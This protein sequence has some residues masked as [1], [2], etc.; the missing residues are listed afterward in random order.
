MK[1]V[2]FQLVDD[3]KYIALIVDDKRVDSG[4]LNQKSYMIFKHF[5]AEAIKYAEVLTEG[6]EREELT[7]QFMDMM[8]E[9]VMDSY[10]L[11]FVPVR[12][13]PL[14]EG[15]NEYSAIRMG[16]KY[17]KQMVAAGFNKQMSAILSYTRAFV[18]NMN[19]EEKQEALDILGMT[20]KKSE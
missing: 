1:K 16:Y 14:N 7:N 18:G 15:I 2:E 6:E 9:E 13:R 10:Y 17:Y 20:I 4:F 19:Y 12:F 8:Q 5:G 3:N 11:M